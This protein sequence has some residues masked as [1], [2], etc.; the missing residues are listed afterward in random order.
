[1]LRGDLDA[2]VLTAL[3]KD[4]ARRYGSAEQ[5]GEDVGRWL[6]GLPVRAQP[7]SFAYRTRK[8]LGRHGSAVAAGALFALVLM[9]AAGV[10]GWQ[11]TRAAQERDRAEAERGK[12]ERVLQLLVD[13]FETS[14]PNVS[15]GGDTLRVSEFLDE[16]ERRLVELDDQPEVQLKLWET[17]AAIHGAR[18]RFD[19]ER[20]ALERAL[21][22][23]RH[24]G[25]ALDTL[26]IL[27]HQARLVA[28]MEGAAA[29]E[30]LFRASL[31]THEAQLGP[32]SPDVAIAA[33]DLAAVLESDPERQALLER[34]LSIRR[35][36]TDP[37]PAGLASA[38]NALGTFHFERGE[39]E[40]ARARFE[41]ALALLRSR[42]PADH[43]AIL[44]IR[45]NV[46]SC[47][48]GAGEFQEAERI[49]RE[50]LATRARVLG[51]ETAQVGTNWQA[52]GVSLVHQ[53]RHEEAA[54]ALE[55]SLRI[56]ERVYGPDHWIVISAR[57][58]VAVAILRCGRT[59]EGLALLDEAIAAA[60]GRPDVTPKDLAY[61][62]A[63]RAAARRGAGLAADPLT[64]ELAT[65]RE[66]YPEGNDHLAYV[67]VQEGI[68]AILEGRS[69][70]A[71]AQLE[72]ADA[73]RRRL[74]T[75][76][77]PTRLEAPL[78]LAIA[79]APAGTPLPDELADQVAAYAGWGLAN[80]WILESARELLADR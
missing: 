26:R 6:A 70:D 12:S 43:P 42:M 23:A 15:P 72:E 38:L 28:G 34:A 40:L 67:L 20:E 22:A 78:A 55:N 32:D 33:Q 68:R 58:N 17:M 25:S 13:L 44:A 27:H 57:R 77:H 16:G 18:S 14:N 41:E 63:Q 21:S 30:P 11:A 75:P 31:A 39:Y 36:E 62:R 3:R 45:T 51:P 8:F 56:F 47:L 35:G 29:A 2:I 80:D 60:T 61:L 74:V 7:D 37:D 71:I 76:G 66:A 52:I 64:D 49:H 54:E 53:G 19:R 48:S 4:P 69:A 5:L 46:A 50:L 1:V 79:R 65:L 10:A 24:T 9:A 59:Q 73:I